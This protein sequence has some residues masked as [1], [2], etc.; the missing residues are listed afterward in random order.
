MPA[1]CVDRI[2]W[3]DH[4]TVV[5]LTSDKIVKNDHIF[6]SQELIFLTQQ[7]LNNAKNLQFLPSKSDVIVTI[8]S[9]FQK[10]KEFAELALYCSQE[11][12]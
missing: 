10:H 8:F 3:C 9:F 2:Q 6:C 12:M 1:S 11:V 4:A 5:L 7:V